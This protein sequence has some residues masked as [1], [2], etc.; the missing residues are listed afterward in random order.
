MKDAFIRLF[1]ILY[2]NYSELII[3][4]H[5]S[6][7]ELMTKNANGS[8]NII[9]LR[10]SVL[11][12]KEQ[13]KVIATLRTKGFLNEAKFME[14]STEVNVR[15]NKLYKDIRLLSQS[16]DTTLND[17]E[18]LIGYF[19]KRELIMVEFEP[20]TFEFLIDKL[21]INDNEL[22]FHMLGGLII[23]ENI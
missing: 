7:Q 18:M 4:M 1:N 16:D 21:V 12:L 23:T 3:S 17:I 8:V 19:E 10:R 9:E 5:K 15:I 20:Q 22:E 2:S 13:L 14:Q 11:K 6:L